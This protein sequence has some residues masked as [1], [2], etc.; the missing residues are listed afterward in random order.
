[1]TLKECVLARVARD[2]GPGLG[3]ALREPLQFSPRGQQVLSTG[4]S[5]GGRGGL[6]FSSLKERLAFRAAAPASAPP[7]SPVEGETPARPASPA[8][9]VPAESKQAC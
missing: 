3:L 9:E 7:G 1:M 5:P 8:A 4:G 6:W 2:A